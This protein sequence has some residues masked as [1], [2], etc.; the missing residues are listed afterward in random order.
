MYMIAHVVMSTCLCEVE[1]LLTGLT[2]LMGPTTYCGSPPVGT[3][4]HTVV[5]RFSWREGM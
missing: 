2:A 4:L 5:L 1:D 3:A